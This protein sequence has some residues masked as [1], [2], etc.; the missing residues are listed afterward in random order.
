MIEET[1]GI[2]VLSLHHDN[3]SGRSC[4]KRGILVANINLGDMSGTGRLR[5][6]R[7]CTQWFLSISG[8]RATG[9]SDSASG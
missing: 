1:V 8:I 7:S 3:L 2:K 5:E 6:N 4:P 9:T